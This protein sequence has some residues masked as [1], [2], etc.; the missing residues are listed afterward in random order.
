MNKKEHQ[1]STLI[2]SIGT[3]QPAGEFVERIMNEIRTDPARDTGL[4]SLLASL[5]P[6]A[7][8]DPF[9]ATTMHRIDSKRVRPIYPPIIPK[10]AWYAA[11][12]FL[13][14]SGIL[15]T[16]IRPSAPRPHS[17]H[18]GIPYNSL[19]DHMG[20]DFTTFIFIL[21]SASLLLTIDYLYRMRLLRAR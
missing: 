9:T 4:G 12:V 15:L 14:L 19:F 5:P 8:P 7:P 10:W 17:L 21:L 18:A 16:A 3:D 2:R 20:G 13:L 1:L 6:N 11:A